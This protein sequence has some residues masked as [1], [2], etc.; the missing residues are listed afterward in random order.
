M[1][2]IRRSEGNRLIL[3]LIALFLIMAG[4]AAA[5]QKPIRI[6]MP[7]QLGVPLKSAEDL[8]LER[9]WGPLA[10]VI[11]TFS[12]LGEMLS[13]GTESVGLEAELGYTSTTGESVVFKQKF[14]GVGFVGM[15]GICVKPSLGDYKALK[16]YDQSKNLEG[17]VWVK[18]AVRVKAYQG[19][20]ENYAFNVKLK[21]SVD[22][23]VV[24]AVNMSRAGKGAPPSKIDFD[25]VAVPGKVFHLLLIGEKQLAKKILRGETPPFGEYLVPNK[26]PGPGE[27]QICFYADYQGMMK[28][29][30]DEEPIVKELKNIKLGCF[31]FEFRETGDFEMIVEKNVTVAPLAEVMASS[32]M[33]GMTPVVETTTIT[34]TMPYTS[35]VTTYLTTVQGQVSTITQTITQ[36]QTRTLTKTRT[37]WKTTTVTKIQTIPKPYPVTVTT[38]KTQ[39]VP[40][41]YAV[42]VTKTITKYVEGGGGGGFGSVLGNV[43]VITPEGRKPIQDIRSGDLVLTESGFREVKEVKV[44]QV[45][46][47][48]KIE[49]EDGRLLIADDAQPVIT[50]EGVKRVGELKIGDELQALNGTSRII[51][52]KRHELKVFV[53]DLMFD[54]PLN[55]YANGVLVNDAVKYSGV[56]LLAWPYSEFI[57]IRGW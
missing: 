30:G 54:E 25:K 18:P 36:Y 21:I 3:A 22:G 48:Y 16:L 11:K 28:F 42:T 45:F 50:S 47:L 41:P 14:S 15:S 34:V 10:P 12:D 43:T 6:S 26:T 8:Q 2:K 7:E 52:I 13:G 56:I 40:E 35:Y 17:Q 1:R 53:Y 55:Y 57:F 38:T 46:N 39:K 31:S 33:E 5:F 20:P 29:E 27:K 19:I 51:G 49:L 44:I 4:I 23:E 32:G 24:H 9:D 37:K